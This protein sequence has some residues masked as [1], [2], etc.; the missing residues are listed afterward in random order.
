LCTSTYVRTLAFDCSDITRVSSWIFL[1]SYR[2]FTGRH[3]KL[4]VSGTSP[5][6]KRPVLQSYRIRGSPLLS[7]VTVNVITLIIFSYQGYTQR[8]VNSLSCR[9]SSQG[10]KTLSKRKV[11]RPNKCFML[12]RPGRH[13]SLAWPSVN[14]VNH[15]KF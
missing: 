10:L 13:P 9:C 3:N 2:F 8:R 12:R 15:T 7:I 4:L 5:Y 1:L 6:Q 14:I 11:T